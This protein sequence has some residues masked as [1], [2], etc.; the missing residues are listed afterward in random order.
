MN[1]EEGKLRPQFLD[2]FGL[3]VDVVGEPDPEIRTEIIRRRM[4][5]ERDPAA[6]CREWQ[7]ESETLSRQVARAKSLVADVAIDDS[8]RRLAGQYAQQAGTEGNRCEVAA[9]STW[10]PRGAGRPARSAKA[11]SAESR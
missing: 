9:I 1:P 11:S 2:R 4:A 10:I 5:Y 6:F 7:N 8:I 3:Y